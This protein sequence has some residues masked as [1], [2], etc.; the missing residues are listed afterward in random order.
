MH[1]QSPIAKILLH[2]TKKKAIFHRKDKTY[3]PM[4]DRNSKHKKAYFTVS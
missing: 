1:P 3:L 2:L 4:K